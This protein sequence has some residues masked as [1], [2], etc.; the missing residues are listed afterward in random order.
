M[1]PRAS[2]C[3]CP[4]L[5]LL[6]TWLGC[7]PV[8]PTPTLA[9]T[10]GDL[11]RAAVVTWPL[12]Q[13]LY[14]LLVRCLPLPLPQPC[15]Y[16]AVPSPAPAPAPARGLLA[17]QCCWLALIRGGGGQLQSTPSPHAGG[18][19][20]CCWLALIRGGGGSRG[21]MRAICAACMHAHLDVPAYRCG[22]D[23]RRA[24]MGVNGAGCV[25]GR[26][27]RGGWRNCAHIM[28]KD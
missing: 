12:P 18:R 1:P 28:R 4:C 11:V 10:A 9:H 27:A 3:P 16:D 7:R 19:V 23:G 5:C 24:W 13:P 21:Y 2:P 26:A 15:W 25:S 14:T 20:Q 6:Q 22:V 17:V 8:P